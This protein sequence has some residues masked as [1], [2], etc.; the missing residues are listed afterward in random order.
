MSQKDIII[1]VDC[2]NRTV[3]MYAADAGIV[4]SG[5]GSKELHVKVPAG[6]N[7]LWHVVPKQHSEGTDGQGAWDAIISKVKLW[8]EDAYKRLISWSADPGQAG[9][10]YY[11]EDGN[12]SITFSPDG[13]QYYSPELPLTG[14]GIY[15]PYV[16]CLTQSLENDPGNV[17]VAYTF[18]CKIY[19]GGTMVHEFNWDP[20]VTIHHNVWG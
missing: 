7:L 18:Y 13:D 2:V 16:S 10:K 1:V 15:R 5:Q 14:Q 11:P 6:T 12:N 8:N 19:R 17:T 4:D 9:Y 3:Q 20:Y